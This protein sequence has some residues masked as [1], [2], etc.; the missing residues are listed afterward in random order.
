MLHSDRIV[1][2]RGADVDGEPEVA[3]ENSRVAAH[4]AIAHQ[5]ESCGLPAQKQVFCNRKIG[6]EIDL[7]IDG[8]DTELHRL[9]GIARHDFH[10]IK[11]HR[12]GVA[13]DN[14]GDCLD[15]RRLAGAVLTQQSVNLAGMQR[16][17]HA[18]K[19]TLSQEALGQA[20]DFE[21]GAS[22]FRTRS[23][24]GHFPAGRSKN[25][26]ARPGRAR[27]VASISSQDPSCCHRSSADR[28]SACRASNPSGSTSAAPFPF[29]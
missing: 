4:F 1:A 19:N 6:Q 16:Q 10:A 26:R 3:Q 11:H 17:I 12:S 28:R 5:P 8:G 20:C 18:I 2:K 21:Q 15:Q 22:K 7:L 9:L 24:R 27:S 13:L 25:G 14:P 23:H 29:P